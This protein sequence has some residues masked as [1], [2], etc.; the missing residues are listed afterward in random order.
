MTVTRTWSS[1][2]MPGGRCVQ[3][4]ILIYDDSVSGPSPRRGLNNLA[5]GKATRVL[6]ALPP[7]WVR[8]QSDAK[9]LQ[10]AQQNRRVTQNF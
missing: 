2:N 4:V 10:G 8:C 3:L 1:K 6:R 9:A 5:Q 7:P